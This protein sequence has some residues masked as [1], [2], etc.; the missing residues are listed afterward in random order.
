[1]SAKSLAE[2]RPDIVLGT[3]AHV[4][5]AD[6]FI[7]NTYIHYGLGNFVWHSDFRGTDTGLLQLTVR[8]RNTGSKVA[9]HTFIPG[10]TSSA[11][12]GVPRPAT[13]T[14][15]QAIQG[16]LDAAHKCSGLASTPTS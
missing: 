6:G 2:N 9:T 1:M 4:L 7:G 3:H 10:V 12:G 8:P 14:A 15:L 16:R 11:T 5:L 13:G